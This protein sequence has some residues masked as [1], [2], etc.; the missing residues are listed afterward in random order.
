MNEL[1]EL[2]GP[3]PSLSPSLS[4]MYSSLSPELQRIFVKAFVYLWRYLNKRPRNTLVSYWAIEQLR[5]KY[6]MPIS[7]LALLTFLFQMSNKGK[8]IINSLSLQYSGALPTSPN[9]LRLLLARFKHRGYIRRFSR[10]P[11]APYLQRSI[12]RTKIFIQFTGKGVEIV[13]R[14]NKDLRTLELN[15]ALKDVTTANIKGWNHSQPP[16]IA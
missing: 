13:E 10:D 12:S 5:I 8:Y 3:A 6:K 2:S 16:Q 14:I 11:S 4:S 7:E 15:T 1:A 9:Y